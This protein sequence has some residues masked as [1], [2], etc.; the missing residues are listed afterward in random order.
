MKPR[1]YM[2]IYVHTYLYAQIYNYC[3]IYIYIYIYLCV[4][5]RVHTFTYAHTQ[6]HMRSFTYVPAA[7]KGLQFVIGN[8]ILLLPSVL[9]LRQTNLVWRWWRCMK[10]AQVGRFELKINYKWV[11]FHFHVWL[12][13]STADVQLCLYIY[14]YIHMHTHMYT[15]TYIYI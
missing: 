3:V 6:R 8:W 4:C 10:Q 9:V 15:H 2:I 11:M 5:V 12:P 1:S 13:E 7:C 14:I